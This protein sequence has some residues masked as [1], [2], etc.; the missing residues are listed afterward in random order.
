MIKFRE[1]A[2]VGATLYSLPWRYLGE[3]VHARSTT[4]MVQF[5]RHGELIKTH[6]V[7]DRGKQTDF[8]DYPPEKIAFHMRTPTWCRRRAADIGP[9]CAGVIDELLADNALFRLRAAQGVLGLADKHDP[10]RLEAACAKAT[11]AGRPVLPHHQ[12]HP[13]RRHRDTATARPTG[14]AG[15]AAHLHGPAQLFADPGTAIPCTAIPRTAVPAPPSP[16]PPSPAPPSPAPP[17]PAPPSPAPP[18]RHRHPRHRH[19]GTAVV[20]CS[21]HVIPLPTAAAPTPRT[22]PPRP[23]HRALSPR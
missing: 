21:R 14:D 17:S 10:A 6:P 18:S 20:P 12:G 19:P 2:K 22:R 11:A 3:R 5:F 9:A 15:A 8:G 1:H 7:K 23:R 4:T 13:R 16:A